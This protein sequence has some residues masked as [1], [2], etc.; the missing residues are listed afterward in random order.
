MSFFQ[1]VNLGGWLSQCETRQHDAHFNSFITA[2][3]IQRIASW[4]FDHV[5]LPVDST[6][7]TKGTNHLQENMLHYI[8]NCLTW[9][10]SEKLGLQLDMHRLPGYNIATAS[11]NTLFSSLEERRRSSELWHTLAQRYKDVGSELR[12]ELLN[13]PEWPTCYE[14]Q[15]T[16]R[17]LWQAIREVD[18]R[19]TLVVSGNHYSHVDFMEQILPF[20]DPKV[21]YTFHYYEPTIFTNQLFAKA[22]GKWPRYEGAPV[23]PGDFP[24]LREYLDQCPWE[25]EV[26]ARYCWQRNDRALMEKNILKAVAFRTHRKSEIYLGEFG[27]CYHAEENRRCAWMKDLLDLTEKYNIPWCYWTYK[28]MDYGLVDLEGSVINPQVLR[29]L[30]CALK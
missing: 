17:E 30:Q 24:G 28:E 20:N 29:T 25:A 5:R 7:L 11:H 1:G 16:Y 8:D 3:D 12:F 15:D 10:Q 13:E 26:N 6:V 18:S 23:Y 21:V 27:V 22:H 19:R 2:Q 4:G 14:V 9:C